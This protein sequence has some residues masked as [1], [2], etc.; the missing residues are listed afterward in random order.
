MI[1]S[2]LED[3][4]FNLPSITHCMDEIHSDDDLRLIQDKLPLHKLTHLKLVYD[5]GELQTL[6]DILK[7]TTSLKSLE[8]NGFI[9][10]DISTFN[11]MPHLQ[12]LVLDSAEL[13]DTLCGELANFAP[14][15]HRLSIAYNPLVSNDGVRA[16]SLTMTKLKKFRLDMV[17]EK[18]E[19]IMDE[20]ERAKNSNRFPSLRHVQSFDV[21][22]FDNVESVTMEILEIDYGVQFDFPDCAWGI[23]DQNE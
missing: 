10:I 17:E 7:A 3:I 21:D 2:V 12:C 22:Y 13:N 1:I 16:L 9:N 8:L 20:L 18:F 5:G 6:N 23:F 14:Q 15:L 19:D 4:P 11:A